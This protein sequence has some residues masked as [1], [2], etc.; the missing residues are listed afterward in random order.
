MTE[1]RRTAA[2]RLR[3]FI[4]MSVVAHRGLFLVR[5]VLQWLHQTLEPGWL[6]GLL[7]VAC[8]ELQPANGGRFRCIRQDILNADYPEVRSHCQAYRYRQLP[9]E[10]RTPADKP[11]ERDRATL[12]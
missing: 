3:H 1:D 6:Q 12:I 2:A 10:V 11:G 8:S 4:K 9:L 5:T 7:C